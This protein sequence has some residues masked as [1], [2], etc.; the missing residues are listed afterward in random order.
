MNLTTPLCLTAVRI[1]EP[2]LAVKIIIV[3]GLI[4]AGLGFLKMIFYLVGELKP[5]AWA[6]IKSPS[7]RKFLTG[8]G[9]RLL[10]GLGGF[11]TILFGLGAIGI[12]LLIRRLNGFG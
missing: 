9:N 8:N 4:M 1:F 3:L 2:D 12:A 10:F 5:N 6:K 7:I 11:I